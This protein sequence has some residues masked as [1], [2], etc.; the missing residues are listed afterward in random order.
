MPCLLDLQGMLAGTLVCPVTRTPL[1]LS[2][3]GNELISDAADLAFPIRDGVPILLV[4]EARTL[5]TD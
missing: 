2:D 3:T 1:R 5:Q 4:R